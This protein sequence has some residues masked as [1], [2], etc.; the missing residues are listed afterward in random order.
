LAK[1]HAKNL[2]NKDCSELSEQ[3]LRNSQLNKSCDNL[4]RPKQSQPR[5]GVTGG[6]LLLLIFVGAQKFVALDG[7]DDA[8][9]AFVASFGAL[10]AAEAA[11]ADW[12]SHG[13]LVGECQQDFDCC[14]FFN[15]FGKEKVHATR[16]DIAGFRAGFT[17]GCAGRPTDGKR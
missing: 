11:Y 13:D 16:A 3:K 17:H 8:N 15:V 2:A 5:L 4:N 9:G 1:I 7:G 6:G 10:H 12:A 14:A